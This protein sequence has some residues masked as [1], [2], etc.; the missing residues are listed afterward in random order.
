MG[1]AWMVRAG[2]A[3]YVIDDFEKEN[4]VAIGWV[5]LKDLSH[6]KSRDALR[7]LME[8]SY[9]EYKPGQH[10]S[11]TTQVGSFL[12]DVKVGDSVVS[13]NTETREYLLGDISGGYEHRPELVGDH[14]HIR[15]V[16]WLGRVSRDDLSPEARNTLGAIQTLF[17][18]GS[19][20]WSELSGLLKGDKPKPQPQEETD[21]LENIREDVLARGYEFIKDRV[22][23][24]AWDD[25]QDLVAGILRA[26][27][28]KTVVSG[29][30]SDRGKD[31]IASPDGLGLEQPRIRVEVKHRTREQMGAPAIRSFIGALR[32]SD[33]GLFISTG[34]F[35]REAHYEAERATIPVTLLDLDALVSLLLQHY[36][37]LDTET[38]AMV[39][40]MRVYWPA[41]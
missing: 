25:M 37:N 30:G 1:T 34:G 15:R 21:E 2:R 40:L 23:K 18:V 33:R 32:Q 28:Y 24:L 14:P 26:M 39:P 3:G 8:R 38:R 9:P 7:A 16:K 41:S 11:A 13:Y 27:G 6:V 22:Q 12:F 31:I 35:S 10:R 17:K 4:V 19:S 36:E 20:V 29:P 5:E